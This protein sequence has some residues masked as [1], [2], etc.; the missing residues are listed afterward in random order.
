MLRRKRWVDLGLRLAWSAIEISRPVLHS[1]TISQENKREGKLGVMV[2][3]AWVYRL[4][5]FSE[6]L[7]QKTKIKTRK[8][9][10]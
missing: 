3:P 10:Y 1:E 5:L 6:N 7:F 2:Y 8:E 4:R 9:K